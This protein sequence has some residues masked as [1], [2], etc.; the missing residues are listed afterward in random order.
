MT[1]CGSEMSWNL[2]N[3]IRI[4]KYLE[5]KDWELRMS[6]QGKSPG[7]RESK[8]VMGPLGIGS[9]NKNGNDLPNKSIEG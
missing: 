5:W 2:N 1:E 4:Q 8:R 7:R 3:I 9:I 6:W